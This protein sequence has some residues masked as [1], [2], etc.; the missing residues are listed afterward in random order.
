MIRGLPQRSVDLLTMNKNPN[1]KQVA[2]NKILKYHE[3]LDM[4][5][6]LEFGL[7]MLPD[8]VEWFDRAHSCPRNFEAN[9]DKKKLSAVY[10]FVKGNPEASEQ[11]WSVM[12]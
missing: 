3:H 12:P 6:L 9:I 11:H 10:E 5:P 8:V 4:T 7:G 1:K 2:M